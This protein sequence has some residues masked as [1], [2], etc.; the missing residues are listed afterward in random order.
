M[1]QVVGI[2]SREKGT[3]TRGGEGISQVLVAG[4]PVARVLR[5][6]SLELLLIAEN[7][8][9]IGV[10]V[11]QLMIADGGIKR[12]SLAGDRCEQ[13]F[14]RLKS[15]RWFNQQGKPYPLHRVPVQ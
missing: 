3:A 1:G 13:V 8:T 9:G 7:E 4:R 15:V 2:Q 10:L 14:K 12:Y 5:K 11:I 6:H